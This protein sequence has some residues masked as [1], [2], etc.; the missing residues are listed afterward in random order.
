M[1]LSYHV[2]IAAS[3]PRW[4]WKRV[5]QSS[6]SQMGLIRE[7]E[8]S[9]ERRSPEDAMISVTG[10]WNAENRDCLLLSACPIRLGGG[11]LRSCSLPC[12]CHVRSARH[13]ITID[14]VLVLRGSTLTVNAN[15]KLFFFCFWI[16]E[17]LFWMLLFVSHQSAGHGVITVGF[18][19][20]NWPSIP[21]QFER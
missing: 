3:H 9:M 14:C 1:T 19:L 15:R 17:H 5:W 8:S 21:N 4:L 6:S 12:S 10:E 16:L 18:V 20:R 13:V 2:P 11:G 7:R